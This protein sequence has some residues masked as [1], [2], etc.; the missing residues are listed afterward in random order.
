MPDVARL[1][2]LVEIVGVRGSGDA[3]RSLEGLVSKGVEGAEGDVGIQ[4]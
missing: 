2:G 4:I 1:I 3:E